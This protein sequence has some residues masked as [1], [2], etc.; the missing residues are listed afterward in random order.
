MGG[1]ADSRHRRR[2]RGTGDRSPL[3]GLG[4]NPPFSVIYIPFFV[5]MLKYRKEVPKLAQIA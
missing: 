5:L 2:S 1:N 4:D 3:L